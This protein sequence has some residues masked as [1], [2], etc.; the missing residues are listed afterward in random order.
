MSGLLPGN[1]GDP[2]G[3]FRRP[4]VWGPAGQA[5]PALVT[6][7]CPTRLPSLPLWLRDG[8][9][10]SPNRQGHVPLAVT[11]QLQPAGPTVVSRLS[12]A[13]VTP[14]RQHPPPTHGP[15]VQ[16]EAL[17][18]PPAPRH[19]FRGRAPPQHLGGQAAPHLL[20][21]AGDPLTEA[22]GRKDPAETLVPTGNATGLPGPLSVSV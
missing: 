20:Y 16:Q 2:R 8:P 13:S 15:R 5:S 4:R 10:P 19:P 6:P 22:S 7:P 1:G 3:C 18:G 9:H 11:L 14:Q 21:D 17:P 12:P